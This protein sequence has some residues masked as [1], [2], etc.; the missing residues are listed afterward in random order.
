MLNLYFS[1]FKENDYILF[2]RPNNGDHRYF[3]GNL[4]YWLLPY[5][6]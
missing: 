2:C 3:G 4:T 1:I 6:F 5:L